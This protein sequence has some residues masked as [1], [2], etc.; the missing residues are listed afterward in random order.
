MLARTGDAQPASSTRRQGATQFIRQHSALQ[1]SS[2]STHTHSG[3]L[4]DGT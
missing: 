4:R 2:P 3:H 1:L